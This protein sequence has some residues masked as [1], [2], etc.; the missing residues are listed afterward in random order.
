[1]KTE[2]KK[3]EREAWRE[4]V[5]LFFRRPV[6]VSFSAGSET[7]SLPNLPGRLTAEEI[8]DRAVRK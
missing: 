5:R 7:R 2:E 3:P 1:M 6:E 4:I 8:V